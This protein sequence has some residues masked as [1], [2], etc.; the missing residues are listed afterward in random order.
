MRLDFN[1]LWIDDQPE[2]LEPQI[3]A[4]RRDMAEH[5]F[6]F[7]PTQ[8]SSLDDVRA[9]ISD[10][11]FTDEIDLI[12]VDWNLGGEVRGQDVIAEIRETIPYKDIVFYSSLT[13]VTD[14]R[15]HVHEVE[16]E[17][18]FCIGKNGLIGEVMGVFEALVKKV[19][20]L[21]HTRGIVMGATSDIDHMTMSCLSAIDGAGSEEEKKVLLDKT[22]KLVGK[23]LKDLAKKAKELESATGFTAMLEAHAFFTAN[24]RLR[25]LNTI[26]ENTKY[27][28][29][30]MLRAGLKTY[31][32]DVVP[33]RNELGHLVL[34]PAG[35][36]SEFIDG[37]GKVVTLEDMRELRK[38]LLGFRSDFRKLR[39]A[40][41]KAVA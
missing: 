39:D 2:Q 1:V 26:L 11:V 40:L 12:L 28:H 15:K 3:T 8:L 13:P 24:D 32:K 6:E 21:D 29:H 17:G 22:K 10:D 36:A 9:L 7:C 20:D 14:L 27:D 38:F 30:E 16:A 23:T 18:V 31:I 25:V 19:L 5:G 35:K 37:A 33:K 4:I 41:N 34:V